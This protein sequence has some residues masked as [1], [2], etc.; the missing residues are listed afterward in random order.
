[1]TRGGAD[2][3]R[4]APERRCLVTGTRGG[5][6]GLVRFVVGPGDVVVPDILGRLPG[7]GMW[8]TADREV[9]ETAVRKRAF[10]RG[11]KKQVAPP[12]DL[13]D[14]VEAALLRRVTDLLSLARKSGAAVAGYEK[15]KAWLVS[16]EAEVLLQ[17]ADGS[18]R[19]K[20]KLR[21]PDGPD[22]LIGIMTASEL[23]LAFGRENVIHGALAGGGLTTRVVEEA[24]RLQGMRAQH[25]GDR[26]VG[27]GTTTI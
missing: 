3:N 11:A 22:S 12:A 26:P 23:G 18:E 19:G 2:K 16:G 7:R 5:K 10:S 8:L 20:A 17:A 6:A 14:M 15:T 21:P 24:A 9:L 4:D 25:V 1:M 27:K 13:A